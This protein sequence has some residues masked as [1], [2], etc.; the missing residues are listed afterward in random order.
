MLIITSVPFWLAF[1]RIRKRRGPR[2][3]VAVAPNRGGVADSTLAV[4]VGRKPKRRLPRHTFA[5]PLGGNWGELGGEIRVN[6][7]KDG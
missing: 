1:G 5:P 3:A 6:L 2:C 7:G 4:G